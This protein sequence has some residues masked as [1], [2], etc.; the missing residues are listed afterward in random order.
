VECPVGEAV[1][2]QLLQVAA[3]AVDDGCS[4]A[5]ELRRRRLLLLRVDGEAVEAACTSELTSSMTVSTF[6]RSAM[7]ATNQTSIATQT[8]ASR[9]ATVS[10]RCGTNS[11]SLGLRTVR[12]TMSA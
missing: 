3:A 5:P 4:V 11:P 6:M 7:W 12:K 2:I 1:G 8:K 10:A 9:I